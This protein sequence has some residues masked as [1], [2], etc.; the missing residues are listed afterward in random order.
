MSIL[1]WVFSNFHALLFNALD[2]F[3]RY[4]LL[5]SL[6]HFKYCSHYQLALDTY[7]FA[8][9]YFLMWVFLSHPSLSHLQWASNSETLGMV[10]MA[11]SLMQFS[12]FYFLFFIAFKHWFICKPSRCAFPLATSAVSGC[13]AAAAATAQHN[14][15][16][17]LHSY[18][19]P[20]WSGGQKQTAPAAPQTYVPCSIWAPPQ[21][22]RAYEGT[23]QCIGWRE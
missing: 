16:A 4:I 9:T 6:V 10:E 8:P 17:A 20:L 15:W 3:L 12:V 5:C 11:S 13:S 22:C 14:Q 1:N 23:C 2:V 21:W 19:S 7:I 18:G